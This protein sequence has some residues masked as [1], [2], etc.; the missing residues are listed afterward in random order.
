MASCLL[1]FY[2]NA[3][4]VSQSMPVG[5]ELGSRVLHEET[6]RCEALPLSLYCCWLLDTEHH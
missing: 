1:G 5:R 4:D 3:C 6:T 2:E